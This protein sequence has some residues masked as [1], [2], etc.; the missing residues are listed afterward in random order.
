MTGPVTADPVLIGFVSAALAALF[1]WLGVRT[2]AAAEIAQARIKQEPGER[3]ALNE[4]V[5]GIIHHY[6][7]ALQS[8]QREVERLGAVI[9][10]QTQ[11][12][13]DLEEHVDTLTA[14]MVKG[15]VTVPARRK[16]TDSK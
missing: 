11:T 8:M 6:T 12:I 2:K 10:E 13:N 14:A 7:S 15:G 3:A 5:S 16:R 9:A 4:A 1:T